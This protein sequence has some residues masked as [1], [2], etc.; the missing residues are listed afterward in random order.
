MKMLVTSKITSILAI[1]VFA[2]NAFTPFAAVY[3]IAEAVS[4]KPPTKISE[5]TSSNKV[6]I[7]TSEGFKWVEQNVSADQHQNNQPHEYSCAI[8]YIA[9]NGVKDIAPEASAIPF[10]GDETEHA[11][12]VIPNYSSKHYKHTNSL[13]Q[14]A[15]PFIA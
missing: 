14:R 10:F 4:A 3:S 13:R 15:P 9:A 12:Y 7:C 6:L 1:I 2:I 5:T 8:C 11:A